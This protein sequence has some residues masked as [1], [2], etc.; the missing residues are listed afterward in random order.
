MNSKLKFNKK[1]NFLPGEIFYNGITL[2]IETCPEKNH[3]LIYD[4]EKKSIMESD[5]KFEQDEN[6]RIIFGFYN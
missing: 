4:E 3:L 5:T 1:T 6:W 2:V